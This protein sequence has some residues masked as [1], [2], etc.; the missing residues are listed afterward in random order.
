MYSDFISS[1]IFSGQQTRNFFIKFIYSSTKG[2]VAEILSKEFAIPAISSGDIFRKYISE[3]TEIG[4]KANANEVYTKTE[5]NTKL[6]DGSVKEV[7]AGKL[8]IEFAKELS[9]SLAK[10]CVCAKVDS[11]LVDLKYPLTKDC[12][13]ELVLQDSKEAFEVLNHSCAHLLAHAMKRL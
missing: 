11:N 13:L 7:E 1:A 5:I 6:I 4:K 3:G 12:T 9:P 8:V 10:K 2:S